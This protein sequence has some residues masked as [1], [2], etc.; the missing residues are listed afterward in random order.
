MKQKKFVI[1]IALI[2]V[3]A[4]CF[5]ACSK[6]NPS[7]DI[8]SEEPVVASLAEVLAHQRS[9]L[10]ES[11]KTFQLDLPKDREVTVA[12]SNEK[13]ATVDGSGLVTA[14]AEGMAVITVSDGEESALCGILVDAQ[15]SMIDVTK[16]SAKEV[17]S[18]LELHSATEIT[19]MAVDTKNQTVYLSQHYGS[20]GYVPLNS[21]IMI[22]AVE[23]KADVWELGS[24][25]RFSGSGKGP[26]CMD[27][28]GQTARLW[29]EC[30][31]DYIGYGKAISLV[32]WSDDT[33]CLDSYGEVFAPQGISGGMTV[34]ADVGNNMILV[35]DR[36]EKCYRIYDRAQML[37]GEQAPQYVHSFQ[38]KANQTPV[39]G[40]DDSQG[41]YNA[42]IRGYALY[43]GYLYQFSGSSS[44]YLSVFDL[45]GNLQYCHRMEDLPDTDYYMPASISIADGKIYVAIASGNSEYNLANLLVFE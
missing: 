41:R 24:W 8:L 11:G 22:S 29:M 25:M 16:L 14:V 4:V 32:D 1:M 39:A 10:L 31:G 23:K 13:V 30:S 33:Y 6:E 27:N 45:A 34:T 2:A 37:A 36:A 21:D 18:D 40:E 26:I 9:Q 15:G 19:G 35:Y 28:D 38:C 3:L 42:S 17:F 12:S 5:A 44:I 43:D 7:S 20:D